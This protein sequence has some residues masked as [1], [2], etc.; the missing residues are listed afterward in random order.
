MLTYRKSL[1]NYSLKH[2]YCITVPSLCQVYFMRII[3]ICKFYK[4]VKKTFKNLLTLALYC[5]KIFIS[6]KERGSKCIN[7]TKERRS[8]FTAPFSPCRR[9]MRSSAFWMTPLPF[10]NWKPSPNGLTL[11][12]A[13]AREEIK[14]RSIRRPA[15]ARILFAV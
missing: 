15:P 13:C 14:L 8:S 7:S 1:A 4:K 2:D 11:L 5:A 10:R 6:Q 9:R 12:A 3:N